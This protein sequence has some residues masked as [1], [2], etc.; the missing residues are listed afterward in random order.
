MFVAL[1][2]LFSANAFAQVPTASDSRTVA[3]IAP[4]VSFASYP[5]YRYQFQVGNSEPKIT[6]IPE[7]GWYDSRIS[8][9]TVGKVADPANGSKRAIRHKLQKGMTYRT[10]DNTA[11]GSILGSWSGS[12]TLKPSTPY[13]AAF[14]FYVDKDHPFNGSG[15]DMNILS[16]GHP[17]SSKNTQSMNALFLHRDGTMRFLVSSNSVLN[18]SNSTYKSA[19]FRKSVQKGVWNYIIVQWKYEW[20]TSKKPYTR[21]WHAV[22]SGSPVQWV[23][24]NVANELRESAGY[25][26]WKFGEYLWDISSG[27]GTTT[28]RTLYTKGIQ[29]FRDQSG[30]PSLTV[31]SLLSLMRSL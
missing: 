17:V 2:F 18:G 16:L 29:I 30:S 7:P 26:P 19:S 9:Y 6:S 8:Q 5:N 22:G 28:S 31:N 3:W 24:T 12:S 11:R 13:W 27:W 4:Q 23:N 20:D 15:N 14:A 25:H 21:V 10:V 1:T